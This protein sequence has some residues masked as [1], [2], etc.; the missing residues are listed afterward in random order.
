MLLRHT[1]DVP[2][3]AITAPGCQNMTARFALTKAEGCPHYAMRVIEFGPGGQTS[4]HGHAEEHEFYFVEGSGVLVDANGCE[5]AFQG[6]DLIYV[7]PFEIHQLK[8]TGTGALTV[9]CTIP[10]LGNGDGRKTAAD[11]QGSGK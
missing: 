4:L 5:T 7:P 3:T 1:K 8:N 10:I 6:G 11:S 2:A 9:I